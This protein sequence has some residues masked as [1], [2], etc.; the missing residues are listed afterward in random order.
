ER[1]TIAEPIDVLAVDVFEDE[2][3]LPRGGHAGIDQ[4]RDVRMRQA[5]QKAAL[6]L[7]ALP[8]AA[9]ERDAEELDGRMALEASVVAF[10]EPHGPHAALTDRRYE[11]VRANRLASD[12]F[13]ALRTWRTWRKYRES[14]SVFEESFANQ[15]T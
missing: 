1:V 12:R 6:A 2:I 5:R 11:N 3:G 7:E 8:A 10:G 9:G 13:M 15:R 14:R 4:M